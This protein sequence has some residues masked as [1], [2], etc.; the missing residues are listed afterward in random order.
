MYL[1]PI[2]KYPEDYQQQATAEGVRRGI[3]STAINKY[4]QKYPNPVMNDGRYVSSR[5]EG[6]TVIHKSNPLIPLAVIGSLYVGARWLTGFSKQG[7]LGKAISENP[8]IGAGAFGAAAALSWA[9]GRIGINKFDKTSAINFHK[10]KWYG[11]LGKD[12]MLHILSGIALSYGIASRAEKKREFGIQPGLIGEAFEKRPGIG[13][14][15][16]ALGIGAGLKLINK[17]ASEELDNLENAILINDYIIEEYP[18]EYLDKMAR[19]SLTRSY[20]R[21]ISNKNT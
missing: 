13:A 17:F 4:Y 5:P 14:G 9:I 10:A 12:Y 8:M 11:S 6:A 18:Q 16:L 21:L 19:Q 20:L 1:I 2:K 7:P 3:A 15:V